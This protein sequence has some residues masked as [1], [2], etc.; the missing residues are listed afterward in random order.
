M[1]LAVLSSGALLG[2]DVVPV[3]VEVHLATGL[4]QF[5]V[6][7]M[8]DQGLRE[9]RERVRS[10]ILS[11]GFEFPAARITVN[12][13]PADLP[14]GSGRFDL[15]IALGV[16]LASG[17]LQ[18]TANSKQTQIIAVDEYFFAGELSLTGAVVD[19]ASSIALGMGVQRLSPHKT[20]MLPTR[21]AQLAACVPQLKVV[22]VGSLLQAVQHL[23]GLTPLAL[24]STSSIQTITPPELCLSAVYGQH[25]A[26]FALELAAAGG[27]SVLMSGPPGVGKSML[28]QRYISL[29]PP[30]NTAQ[31][32]E[33]ALLKQME[34]PLDTQIVLSSRPPYRAPHHSCT[35]A[36]LI[37]GGRRIGPGEI[38]LAHHGVL[39][40][41]ELPEFARNVLEALREPLEVGEVF[42]ARAN[43]RCRFPARF[44]LIAAMNPCPCGYL[45]HSK[46]H[47]SCTPERIKYYQSKISG[48]FMERID[49]YV[50]LNYEAEVLLNPTPA[51]SSAQIRVRV[52]KAR[53]Q[54]LQRQNKLNSELQGAQL[55][56]YAA[57]TTEAHQ[58][59]LQAMQKWGWSARV[60]Q[61]L[62]KLA[63]TVADLETAAEITAEHMA[64][65]MQFRLSDSAH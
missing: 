15:A 11:S 22:G 35:A 38:S 4:P 8:A 28:A 43:Q 49:V 16:L 29:L 55:E 33:V 3:R 17:Q 57:L 63:R 40:L 62:K 50:R 61:R 9:S 42:I 12:L 34:N 47:C 2:I 64:V 10:A 23:C 52:L 27:H 56:R 44:Q 59:L 48:P 41:D 36:A 26:R 46:R 54:Q 21:S 53:Q 37:G 31:Q 20:L 32:L 7:G 58:V 45:G 14:K 6:V 13:A 60:V 30:L 1:S 65:A 51:E 19:I 18:T 25:Q 24:V 5:S 39:F